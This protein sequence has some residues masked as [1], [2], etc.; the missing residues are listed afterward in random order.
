MLV[1]RTKSHVSNEMD[2]LAASCKHLLCSTLLGNWISSIAKML[3]SNC[4]Q[5]DYTDHDDYIYYCTSSCPIYGTSMCSEMEKESYISCQAGTNNGCQ[6]N[7]PASLVRW[8]GVFFLNVLFVGGGI[9]IIFLYL[10][11]S[12][13]VM[14]MWPSI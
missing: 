11:F 8:N 1:S 14:S 10:W 5:Y 13:Y 7:G 9:L 2:L 4:I 12:Y 3:C 6:Q